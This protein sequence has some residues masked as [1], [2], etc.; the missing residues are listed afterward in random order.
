M[1]DFDRLA[2]PFEPSKISWRIGS[3]SEKDGKS[4]GMALAYIDARDVMERLDEVV[5]PEGW[6][7]DYPHAGSKTVC[8]IGIFI[9]G[10]WVWKSDGAGDTDVE[11]EKG[12][13]SDAFKRAAVRWGIGR[14]LYEIAAPWVELEGTGKF[15]KI[16]AHEHTKLERLLLNYRPNVRPMGA[17]HMLSEIA[18][19]GG[20]VGNLAALKNEEAFRIGYRNASREDKARIMAA[21]NPN[22]QVSA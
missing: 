15:K 4:R 17:E 2:S 12:S 3:V 14:Y 10:A 11:A 20:D 9:N 5:G 21:L 16:A 1:I 19:C 7:N 22:E 8:R 18:S 13:L 6:Q